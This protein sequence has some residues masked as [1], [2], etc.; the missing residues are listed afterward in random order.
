LSGINGNSYYSGNYQS[1]ATVTQDG[2]YIFTV[3]ESDGDTAGAIFTIDK[4][5]PT[6]TII[7]MP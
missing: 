7:Y 6:A 3:Y 1:G 4:T 2:T 5:K